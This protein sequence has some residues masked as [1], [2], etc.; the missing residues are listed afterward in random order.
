MNN[1]DVNIILLIGLPGAGK[2]TLGKQL[3]LNYSDKE[4]LFIDDISKVT[5][6]AIEYLSKINNNIK[7]II[8]SDVFFC[9]KKVLDSAILI[10][11]EVFPNCKINKLYFEN[12]KDKCIKNIYLRKEKGDIRKVENLIDI[13]SKKYII[14]ENIKEIKINSF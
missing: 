10:I 3:L 9:D 7:T 11:N 13:L 5:N 6:S 4:A 1:S 14:D 2:T 8:I 12:N